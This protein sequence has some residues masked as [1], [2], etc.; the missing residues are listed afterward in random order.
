[1]LGS[2][3]LHASG[4]AAAQGQLWIT[5][6]INNRIVR[7]D[8]LSGTQLATLDLPEPTGPT[9]VAVSGDHVFVAAPRANTVFRVDS[10]TNAVSDVSPDIEDVRT[11]AALDNDL[12]LVS[13]STDRIARLDVAAGRVAVTVDVCDTP[14]AI[15]ATP[16]GAWVAC[17]QARVLWRVDRAGT[18]VAEI[19]LDGAPTA[20]AAEG[21]RAWV[22]L[23]AD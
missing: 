17:S 7:L 11:L 23:R 5:D 15:A 19:D 13:P 12:W 9:D 6:D 4:I 18:V 14:V 21:E 1:L 22:T 16:T 3:S 8:P 20:V 2:L 10:T